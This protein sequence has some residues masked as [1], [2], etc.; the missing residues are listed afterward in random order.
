MITP[1]VLLHN[2]H[3]MVELQVIPSLEPPSS[4]FW[5]WSIP[6]TCSF[7]ILWDGVDFRDGIL[8]SLRLGIEVKG[9]LVECSVTIVQMKYVQIV[10]A[11][12]EGNT[13]FSTNRV[14]E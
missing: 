12:V 14:A 13:G 9:C 5:M 11:Y 8:A 1:A 3:V 6:L 4:L 10:G 7:F 2:P